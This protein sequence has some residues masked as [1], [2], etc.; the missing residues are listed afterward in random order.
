VSGW[1]N[2]A[3]GSGPA[4]APAA[5]VFLY[6]PSEYAGFRVSGPAKLARLTGGKGRL[7]LWGRATLFWT[8]SATR[9]GQ[10]RKRAGPTGRDGSGSGAVAQRQGVGPAGDSGLVGRRGAHR[11]RATERKPRGRLQKAS[12]T[13]GQ[14][15]ALPKL[16]VFLAT[17]PLDSLSLLRM[18]S[19]ARCA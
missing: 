15:S 19:R 13:F 3:C 1:S 11:F 18:K 16:I 12:A 6:R 2:G 9:R 7:K 4:L 17:V 5:L 10:T 14:R 8:C